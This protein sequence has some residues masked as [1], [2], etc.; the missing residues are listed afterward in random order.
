MIMSYVHGGY[1]Y[2]G[3]LFL[4]RVDVGVNMRMPPGFSQEVME[5]E[6]NQ[7]LEAVKKLE[8]GLRT[9]LL[10][11]NPICPAFP[12]FEVSKDEYVVRAVQKAH[13]EIFGKDPE[14]GA[15]PPHNYGGTDAAFML[16]RKG[17]PAAIYGPGGGGEL[18][19]SFS[20]PERIRI[21]DLVNVA[22]V[23]ALAGLDICTKKRSEIEPQLKL[24][25]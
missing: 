6:L 16:E 24:P 5:N 13:R 25:V 14:I 12:P 19:G 15:V 18:G 2:R 20:P 8:P 4:D 17:V 23:Y 3:G 9:E 21:D 1:E 10:P 22:K 11:L 7:V